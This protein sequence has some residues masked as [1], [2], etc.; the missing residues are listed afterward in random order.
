[1]PS[2]DWQPAWPGRSST[3]MPFTRSAGLAK[4]TGPR[5]LLPSWLSTLPSKA[6][7]G[8]EPC[9]ANSVAMG[10]PR[11]SGDTPRSGW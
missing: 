6:P 11:V 1:M 9:T 3:L 8:V 10:V 5:V 4:S 7:V 2:T